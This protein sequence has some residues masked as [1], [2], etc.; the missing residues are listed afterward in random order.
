M[1]LTLRA[2]ALAMVFALPA[3]AQAPQVFHRVATIEAQRMLPAERDRARRSIAEIVAAAPDRQ[4][5]S[6]RL[7]RGDGHRGAPRQPT[8]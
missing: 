4:G 5:E 1:R 3:A 7:R 2:L 6:L 8:L